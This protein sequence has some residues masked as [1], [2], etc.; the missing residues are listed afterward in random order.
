MN[1]AFMDFAALSTTCRDMFKATSTAASATGFIADDANI[2]NIKT[3]DYKTNSDP[4][5]DAN[6]L[7]TVRKQLP[8]Y[9]RHFVLHC[10]V[11]AKKVTEKD[12]EDALKAH[13]IQVTYDAKKRLVTK[14]LK[15]LQLLKSK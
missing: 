3:G 5:S 7:D 11:N 14:I 9:V 1:I 4:T 15:E 13:N 12:L 8:A 2:G 6:K 10:T